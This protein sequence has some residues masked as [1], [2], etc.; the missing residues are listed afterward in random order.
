MSRKKPLHERI[1]ELSDAMSEN[2]RKTR[3]F[4]DIGEIPPAELASEHKRLEEELT[5]LE[6]EKSEDRASGPRRSSGD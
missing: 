1:I 2:A 6:R 3:G 4:T 5:A